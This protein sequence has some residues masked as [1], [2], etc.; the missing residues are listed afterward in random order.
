M[1]GQIAPPAISQRT[2][3]SSS[4]LPGVGFGLLSTATFGSSGVMARSLLDAGWSAGAAV[5]VRIGL[6]ALLLIG[7]GLSALR[8][9]WHLVRRRAGLL[10]LFGL[11]AVAGSQ[12]CYF[13]AVQHVS[14]GVALLL[15]YSG[16]VLIVAWVWLRTRVRP[17]T[18]TLIG[19]AVAIGGLA[20]VLDIGGA[21]H[22]SLIGVLWGLGAAV[23][24]AV[25]YVLA[26]RTEDGLPPLLVVTAGMVTGAVALALAGVAG[27]LPMAISFTDVRLGSMA[28]SWLVPV[29][30]L[31]LMTA[32]VAYVSG[33][34]AGR[35]LGATMASF[36]GLTEVLFAVLFAWLLLG[37]VLLLSGVVRVRLGGGH[38]RPA[39]RP[40]IAGS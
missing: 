27:I 6:A 11:F 22:V 12:G 19:A 20:L 14:I 38:R 31:G 29:A 3:G 7:P 21:T 17:A 30:W 40:V 5:L 13:N 26:A 2:H 24:L 4:M 32:A 35:R 34:Q 28:L 36:L 1:T 8:G 16:I 15:E 25:Y 23:G 39:G 33:V 9:R 18:M 37:W 10:A